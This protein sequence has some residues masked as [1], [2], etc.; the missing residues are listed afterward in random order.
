M[1]VRGDVSDK[2]EIVFNLFADPPYSYNEMS[3][4]RRNHGV[5]NHLNTHLINFQHVDGGEGCVTQFGAHAH[6]PNTQYCFC[7]INRNDVL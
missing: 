7:L 3:I 6:K 5:V 4:A 2:K 1:F